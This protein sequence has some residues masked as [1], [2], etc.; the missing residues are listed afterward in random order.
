MTFDFKN[1][2][3]NSKG[4]EQATYNR[5]YDALVPES[6]DCATVEGELLRAISKVYYDNY[7][8]GLGNDMRGP[9]A[10]IIRNFPQGDQGFLE[11]LREVAPEDMF[12]K[13]LDKEKFETLV[14]E[15][16]LYVAEREGKGLLAPLD[17]GM[18]DRSYRDSIPPRS[19]DEDDE[20]GYC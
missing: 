11:T 20:D 16:T 8:N 17:V 1:S 2:Y 10:F 3:W 19:W 4:P 7:N 15:I 5:L 12:G 18:W 13:G 6:G 14:T 9:V